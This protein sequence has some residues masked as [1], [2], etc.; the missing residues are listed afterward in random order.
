[1][2]L[3]VGV[4]KN[5]QRSGLGRVWWQVASVPFR[6]Y[7]FLSLFHIALLAGLF[8]FNVL[9]VR[10]EMLVFILS[11]AITGPLIISVL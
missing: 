3:A 11:T 6:L 5:N 7:L 9:T 1:M 4:I 2:C 10:I 8:I